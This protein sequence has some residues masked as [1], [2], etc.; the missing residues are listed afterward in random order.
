M[1]A[2]EDWFRSQASSTHGS[3]WELGWGVVIILFVVFPAVVGRIPLIP[4]L[5]YRAIDDFA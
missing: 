3:W 1:K 4:A 5:F 2:V